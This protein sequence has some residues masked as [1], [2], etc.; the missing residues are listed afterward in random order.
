MAPVADPWNGEALGKR[1][2]NSDTSN[3]AAA[4]FGQP[5]I[6]KLYVVGS[7]PIARSSFSQ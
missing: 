3:A 1:I 5:Q 4:V 2:E 6:P 7:I